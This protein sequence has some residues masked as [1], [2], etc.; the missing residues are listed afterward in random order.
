MEYEELVRKLEYYPKGTVINISWDRGN[1]KFS[2]DYVYFGKEDEEVILKRYE[3]T[4]KSLEEY[5]DD[6]VFDISNNLLNVIGVKVI[7]HKSVKLIRD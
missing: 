4:R 3:E 6:V 5:S 7:A 1:G 2:G